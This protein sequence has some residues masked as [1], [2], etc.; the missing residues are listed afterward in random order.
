MVGKGDR[1]LTHGGTGWLGYGKKS[2]QDRRTAY[3]A[4][5]ARSITWMVALATFRPQLGTSSGKPRHT[6]GPRD[7]SS[8]VGDFFRQATTYSRWPSRRFVRSWGLLQASHDIQVALATFRPQLGTSSGKPR[9]TG[10]PRDVS[11]AVGDFFRQATT[12]RWPS[13]RFVRSWGL[14]Q[15]SHDIQ[16]ALATFRPQLGTSSG[17][18]RHTGGPRDVSSAVGDFFRQATTYRWPSRRFVRS[19][20]LLQASHD[21]QVAL[22]TFRPQLGTSSG[23]PRHT[24]GPRDVSS[25]VGDFFRQ[26]T[27][28]SRYPNSRTSYIYFAILFG[29]SFGLYTEIKI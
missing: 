11:S 19:W 17:K 21:I 14:L 9:H 25:A 29:L 22:A 5:S 18:P 3:P 23:K 8:A 1:P 26:A 7:V 4:R 10:G 24:G 2:R 16:V 6:G 27:T 20:G 15:A 12:Y 13:R 28:Y